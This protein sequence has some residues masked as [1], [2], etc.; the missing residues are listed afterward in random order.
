MIFVTSD[1]DIWSF[2]GSSFMLT[3]FSYCSRHFT[4]AWAALLVNCV[5]NL[6]MI[7]RLW[8]PILTNWVW[9]NMAANFVDNIFKCIFLNENARISIKISLK[10]VP[11]GPINNIP[12]LVQTMSLAPTRRQSIIWTNDGKITDAYISTSLGLDELRLG[13]LTKSC[14][15]KYVFSDIDNLF[16]SKL[17]S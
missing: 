12:T 1:H 11:Q 4:G 14:D 3:F 5:S 9:D 8:H 2:K 10:F 6:R 7:W 16:H 13:D 17:F 15:V